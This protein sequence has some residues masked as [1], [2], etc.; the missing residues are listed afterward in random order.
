[1]VY[2]RDWVM[3]FLPAIKMI[4]W[5]AYGW[6]A[7]ATVDEDIILGRLLAL[8]QERAGRV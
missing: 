6:V 2:H 1:M 8:N 5:A 4:V 7:P 3:A